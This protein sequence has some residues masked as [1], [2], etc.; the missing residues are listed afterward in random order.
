M[1][2]LTKICQYFFVILAII[3]I[4]Y[5]IIL[6]IEDEITCPR[7]GQRIFVPENLPCCRKQNILLLK[8]LALFP[9]YRVR[10]HL[11]FGVALISAFLATL[12]WF[13][14]NSKS[15]LVLFLIILIT[16]FI[17]AQFLN[18]FQSYH[19]F[20]RQHVDNTIRI[21]EHLLIDYDNKF[22]K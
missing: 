8:K 1:W 5:L 22:L 16:V 20:A 11:N 6:I 9:A 7:Q 4:I 14:I 17:L 2:T 18:N 3:I 21:S 10:W 19:G 13:S 12:V 15:F